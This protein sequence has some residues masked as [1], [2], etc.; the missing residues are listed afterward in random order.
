MLSIKPLFFSSMENRTILINEYSILL[1]SEYGK[2]YGR[3]NL[4]TMKQLYLMF[5]K[6]HA[7]RGQ[8]NW[9]N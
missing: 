8:L 3:S 5:P 7:L 9:L 4:M 6:V 1:E 2:K